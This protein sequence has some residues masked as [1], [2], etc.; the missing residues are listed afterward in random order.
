MPV[1]NVRSQWE[2]GNLIFYRPP[3][4]EGKLISDLPISLTGD[5][6]YVNLMPFTSLDIFSTHHAPLEIT[7]LADPGYISCTLTDKPG[8]QRHISI[9]TIDGGIHVKGR[10]KSNI[11]TGYTQGNT[12]AAGTVTLICLNTKNDTW[13]QTTPWSLIINI[14]TGSVTGQF[15]IH[16]P[17]FT[18]DIYDHIE[19]YVT[20]DGATYYSK[21]S[22]GFNDFVSGT[23]TAEE[24]ITNDSLTAGS[25]VVCNVVDTTGFHVG[26]KVFVS[27]SADS[28]WSRIKSLIENTSITITSLTNNYTKVNGAKLNIINTTRTAPLSVVHRNIGKFFRFLPGVKSGMTLQFG[29]P[30]HIDPTEPLKIAFQYIARSANAEEQV[31]KLRTQYICSKIYGS[32]PISDQFATLSYSTFT[33]TATADIMNVAILPEIPITDWVEN[34]TPRRAHTM[35]FCRLGDDDADTYTGSIDIVAVLYIMKSNKFGGAESL[36]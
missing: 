26:N 3:N 34:G 12:T 9:C 30:H 4:S 27:D 21:G 35:Q 36:F 29:I 13:T 33:P 15:T 28:E 22:Y 31:V 14:T 2:E 17:A 8:A 11:E 32:C 10:Q 18:L 19:F 7:A 24:L 20:N 25:N 1:T 6:R 16:C 23:T 5:G